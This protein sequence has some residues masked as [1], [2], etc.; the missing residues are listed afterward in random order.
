MARWC[1]GG[2]PMSMGRE[3]CYLVVNGLLVRGGKGEGRGPIQAGHFLVVNGLLVGGGKPIWGIPDPI[4]GHDR[5]RQVG[6][7]P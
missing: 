7:R 3:G 6:R 2:T 4:S 1:K 5:P